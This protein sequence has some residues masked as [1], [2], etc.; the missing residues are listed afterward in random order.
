MYIIPLPQL[1]KHGLR[2][3]KKCVQDHTILSGGIRIQIQ[4]SPPSSIQGVFPFWFGDHLE[5]PRGC[6]CLWSP[7]PVPGIWEG[8]PRCSSPSNLRGG[9]AHQPSR[10]LT[11]DPSA[12]SSHPTGQRSRWAGTLQRACAPPPSSVLAERAPGQRGVDL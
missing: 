7:C 8:Q 10:S 11:W 3:V 12:P 2:E 1:R 4:V 6:G 5:A 9:S